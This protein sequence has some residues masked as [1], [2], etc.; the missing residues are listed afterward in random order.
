MKGERDWDTG[1]QGVHFKQK[2]SGRPEPK[3]HVRYPVSH[4]ASL[5]TG[6]K[7]RGSG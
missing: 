3:T 4:P 6:A 5:G 1:R 7:K 2:E